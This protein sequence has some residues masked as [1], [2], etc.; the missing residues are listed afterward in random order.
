MMCR[1][2][3][4]TVLVFIFA[5][6]CEGF[7]RYVV[8]NDTHPQWQANDLCKAR[9]YYGLA[10]ID[11]PEKWEF[12]KTSLASLPTGNSAWIGLEFVTID[13]EPKWVGDKVY[14]WGAWAANEPNWANTAVLVMHDGANWVWR[15]QGTN[16]QHQVMC[17]FEF[18]SMGMTKHSNTNVDLDTVTPQLTKTATSVADC[19][20]MCAS[21]GSCLY[22]TYDAGT[23]ACN[24]YDA[25]VTSL[26]TNGKASPN[27]FTLYAIRA[28]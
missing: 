12:A 20:M 10:V 19:A 17:Y 25:G 22:L 5:E 23:D 3:L 4:L 1:N 13:G 2:F 26:L 18:D 8:S 15:T 27:A 24:M 16:Y 21:V 11:T 6:R 28:V 9:G 7:V 14:S